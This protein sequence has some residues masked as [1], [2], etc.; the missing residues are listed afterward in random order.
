MAEEVR[1][2]KSLS[3]EEIYQELFPQLESL[4][5]P[6]EPVLSSLSNLTAALRSA[7]DNI[8][9]VGFYINNS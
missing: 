6:D 4:M 2:D 5:D 1:V 8:S 3:K 7:F 9:W